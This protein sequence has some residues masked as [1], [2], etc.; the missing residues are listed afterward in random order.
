MMSQI[1]LLIILC[2]F[3]TSGQAPTEQ[4]IDIVAPNNQVL[5][6]LRF[7]SDEAFELRNQDGQSL[8]IEASNQVDGFIILRD[9]QERSFLAPMEVRGLLQ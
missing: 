2:S 8:W 1:V 3:G 9:R 5:G 7:G 4:V 6:Q